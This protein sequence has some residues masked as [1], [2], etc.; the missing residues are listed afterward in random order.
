MQPN[1]EQ[2]EVIQRAVKRSE[3]E[4]RIAQL[5]QAQLLDAERR[6]LE[7]REAEVREAEHLLA[8]RQETGYQETERREV[9]LQ[10]VAWQEAQR[11]AAE[12][13]ETEQRRAEQCI[14]MHL[15]SESDLVSTPCFHFN[16]NRREKI[17]NLLLFLLSL[18]M[19]FLF[20]RFVL[21]QFSRLRLL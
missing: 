10:Q 18:I 2:R 17:R 19:V 14:T 5:L 1:F 16:G 7:Q 6:E 8:E 9:E 4:L 21:P 12:H 3:N 20:F 15:G 11:Q 13:R